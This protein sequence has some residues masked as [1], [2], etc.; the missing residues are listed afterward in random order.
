MPDDGGWPLE[1]YRE[2]LRLLAR[3]NLG[4]LL[5][6]KIDPSD[7]VQETMLRAHRHAPQFRGSTRPEWEAFLRRIL[8]STL[9]DAARH[10]MRDK[11]DAALERSL[12][13]ELEASSGRLESWLTDHEASPSEQVRR[14]ELLAK[15]AESLARLPEAQRTALE[16]RYLHQPP[17][18]LADIAMD[19]G[20]TEKAVAGLLCR[21]LQELRELL[22]DCQ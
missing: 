14:Q 3:L 7:V 2:Y 6:S 20:R 17:C 4:R 16:L 8:A 21:G 11:R 22:R 1:S 15:L 19:L 5:R 10:Y 18:S 9:A 12:E 13:A